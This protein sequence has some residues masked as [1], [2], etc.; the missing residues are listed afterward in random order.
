MTHHCT[1]LAVA[2]HFETLHHARKSEG[3]QL[4]FTAWYENLKPLT[5]IAQILGG[6]GVV[7]L[8]LAYAKISS[9]RRCWR[10][11]KRQADIWITRQV[12]FK[13]QVPGRPSTTPRR[14]PEPS[15][16]RDDILTVVVEEIL[17]DAGFSPLQ[18]QQLLGM[19][20]L[21]VKG[22]AA[23]KFLL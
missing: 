22:M 1:Q 16:F 2:L 13:E 20:T 4:D 21:I 7:T 6:L 12:E 11:F 10:R 15:L 8:V 17:S 3:R 19:S 5:D 9:E 14:A 23:D 18:V